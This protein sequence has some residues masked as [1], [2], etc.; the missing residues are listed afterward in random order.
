LIHECVRPHALCSLQAQQAI[1]AHKQILRG[2]QPRV[3]KEQLQELGAQFR[4]RLELHRR[5]TGQSSDHRVVLVSLDEDDGIPY[6]SKAP[7]QMC[8]TMCSS[9]Y[10]SRR[11]SGQGQAAGGSVSGSCSEAEAGQIAAAGRGLWAGR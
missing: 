6:T 7:S 8:S 10:P 5:S 4:E 3:N 9:A 1:S 2:A 11:A